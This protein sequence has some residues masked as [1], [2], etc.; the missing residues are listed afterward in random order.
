MSV[1]N[2]MGNVMGFFPS[3]AVRESYPNSINNP[4]GYYADLPIVMNQPEPPA[5]LT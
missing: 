5:D 4:F 1:V 3:D 2:V